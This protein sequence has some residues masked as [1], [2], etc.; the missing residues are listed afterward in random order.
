MLASAHHGLL[1]REAG[2]DNNL[3]R[4]SFVRRHW[5]VESREFVGRSRAPSSWVARRPPGV[6][7]RSSQNV[8][9]R[10]LTHPDPSQLPGTPTTCNMLETL[11]GQ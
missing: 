4:E 6:V 8:Y 3:D 9:V 5:A 1:L 11:T 7:L 2:D 10:R